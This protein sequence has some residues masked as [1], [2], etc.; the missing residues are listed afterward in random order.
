MVNNP[1]ETTNLMKIP[2]QRLQSSRQA[3]IFTFV[4]ISDIYKSLINS[5]K[6]IYSMPHKV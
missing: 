4:T 6:A 2:F 1:K 5:D 3:I